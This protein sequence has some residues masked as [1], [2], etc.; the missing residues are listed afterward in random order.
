[1]P[2]IDILIMAILRGASEVL[3]ID[4]AAH[5]LLVSWLIC[6][7]DRGDLLTGA[8]DGGIMVALL[9]YFWRDVGQML[10]S[11]IRILR[12][13]SDPGGRLILQLL[14]GSLPAFVIV[15]VLRHVLA[16][17]I[18]QPIYVAVL[19]VTFAV[20]LYVADQAGL[21]VRRLEQMKTGQAIVVGLF[22]G[23]AVLPGVSRIGIAATVGRILGYEREDTAR[24]ALLLTIPWMAM[25]GMYR[26]YVGLAA[27]EAPDPEAALLTAIAAGITALIAV[28]FLMYW[29]RRRGFTLFAVYRVLLGAALIYA[30]MS[31]APAA[32]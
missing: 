9:L 11:L 15:F 29:L 4:F 3:P 5:G 6:W 17:Q 26:V 2:N 25:S 27:R 16:V 7:P 21:T 18:T 8:A 30:L 12:G 10:R 14:L 24:F 1:V 19:L 28:A 22:Q 31:L 23:L 32:C 20:V 13:K